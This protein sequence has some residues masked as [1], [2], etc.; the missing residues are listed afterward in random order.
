LFIKLI[1]YYILLLNY[2]GLS[3]NDLGRCEKKVLG[4]LKFGLCFF[5]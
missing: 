3:K 5:D 1:I 4:S 2:M